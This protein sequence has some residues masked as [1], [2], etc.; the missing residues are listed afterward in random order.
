MLRIHLIL[1]RILDPPWKNT[2]PGHLLIFFNK[3]IIF[4]FLIYF[5]L[6]FYP[7]TLFMNHEIFIISRF[8]KSSYFWFRSKTVFLQFLVDILS[9]GSG[10]QN[11]ADHSDPDPKHCLFQM[12]IEQSVYIFPV[13]LLA[14]IWIWINYRSH[15]ST[16]PPAVQRFQCLVSLMLSSQTKDEINFAAMTKLRAH[17]LTVQNILGRLKN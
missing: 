6:I 17:G 8:F 9:L 2:D 3:K 4:K 16:A 5:F 12:G 11:L 10:S 13:F 1:I 7:K 15:D 14:M